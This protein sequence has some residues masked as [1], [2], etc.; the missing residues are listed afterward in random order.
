MRVVLALLLAMLTSPAMAE[1]RIRDPWPS[2]SETAEIR[3]LE[4]IFPSTSPFTPADI[5]DAEPTT[6]Q[7][8][9][10]LP[11]GTLAPRSV[12]AV[13]MLHGSG[14]VLWARELTYGAQLAT[15]GV[16]ALVVDSFAPR[17]DRA[18]TFVERLLE[19]TESM[20]LADAYAA[21]A[22]LADRPEIDPTR[23]VLAGFSYG[24][25][26]T[27]Y[28][29][30]AQVAE[31]L[32]PSGL[33]FAGHV[34]FYGP[35]I[36]RF[37]DRRTTGAPLLMLYGTG[38]ELID[39]DRCRQIAE[40]MREGGS[41]VETIA[42]NGAVHQW[43]GGTPLRP[44][45]RLLNPCR[46]IVERDGTVRDDRTGLAMGGPFL[47]KISLFLCVENRPYMMGADAEIRALSNRDLG[48]FLTR[49]FGRPG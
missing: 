11:S 36:A 40:D 24:A 25:M 45:G 48:R 12:P 2:L 4:I 13:I 19:I 26:S 1:W 37:E 7:G 20:V 22:F 31:K 47:R 41:A 49:V 21:L 15:M 43:D 18:T 33:R 8:R 16:A 39:P 10:F 6:A 42:Y 46:F 14:G 30:Q 34:A 28:A 44:I 29:L 9:L 23:V 38:D 35:C 3:S 17:R 27:M 32:A 5:G